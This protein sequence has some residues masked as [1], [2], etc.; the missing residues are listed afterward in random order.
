MFKGY[1][2]TMPVW[3]R[4]CISMLKILNP[5]PDLIVRASHELKKCLV[6]H[7]LP[8]HKKMC[9]ETMIGQ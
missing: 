1:F 2:I 4:E 9:I 5:D 7:P 6:I 3:L 8:L